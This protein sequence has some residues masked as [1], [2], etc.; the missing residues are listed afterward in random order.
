VITGASSGIGRATAHAFARQGARVVLAARSTASLEEVRA[1]CEALGGEA[2][3]VPTDVKSDEQ[4]ENLVASALARYG[5]IDVWV[6]GASVFVYGRFD[7]VP[8]V[9]FR[10]LLEVNLFGQ[11]R[12]V[13]AVLPHMQRQGGGTIVLIGSVY[14]R[15]A[16]AYV[17]AYVTSKHALLGL[18][19]SIRQEVLEQ[20]IEVC[21]VLPAT[22]DTPI[23]QHAANYLGRRAHPLPPIIAPERVA[24]VIVRLADRP[25]AS[26]IVGQVQRFGIPAHRIA[27]RLAG[28]LTTRV[29]K[30]VAVQPEPA[31]ET[32]GTVFEP[33]PESNAVSGGWRRKRS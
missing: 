21:A 12:G 20:G 30:R 7:Q 10:E 29:M 4:V 9:V 33:R 16:S 23:Y 1:E 26:V 25:R 2:L 32:D 3:V 11:A 6:G 24:R 28:W 22:A 15:L 27:P 31:P 13:R 18:A 19:D 14:S 17:S 5:R 8:E